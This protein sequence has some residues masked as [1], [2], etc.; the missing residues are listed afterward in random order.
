MGLASPWVVPDHCTRVGVFHPAPSDRQGLSLQ[1]LDLGLDPAMVRQKPRKQRRSQY[2]DCQYPTSLVR[3]LC[4]GGHGR[5]H[6]VEGVLWQAFCANL[7][8][9]KKHRS[10]CR[11][12][13]A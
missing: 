11:R 13:Y 10:V 5:T 4:L 12:A 8:S 7:D 2:R 9:P 6:E 1:T 3:R